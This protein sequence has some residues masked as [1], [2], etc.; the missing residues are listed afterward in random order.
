MCQASKRSSLVTFA[1]S[2]ESKR[3]YAEQASSSLKN[4]ELFLKS[5]PDYAFILLR[6]DASIVGSRDDAPTA[7]EVVGLVVIAH[8]A[9]II[10]RGPR[11]ELHNYFVLECP[12]LALDAGKDMPAGVLRNAVGLRRRT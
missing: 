2:S 3:S 10:G 7:D 4:H 1:Q 12:R 9:K 8:H 11:S 5:N 6:P